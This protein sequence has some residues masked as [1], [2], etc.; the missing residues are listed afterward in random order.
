MFS[1]NILIRGP[2]IIKTT[3]S[4]V[5]TD[6]PVLNVRYLNTFRKE[7]CSIRDVSISY[8]I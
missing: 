4:E 2:P 3:I 5:T 7:Y 1:E 8:N 6:R